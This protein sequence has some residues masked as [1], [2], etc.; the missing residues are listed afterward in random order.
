MGKK[1]KKQAL[2]D[3]AIIEYIFGIEDFGKKDKVKARFVKKVN[4]KYMKTPENKF[5]LTYSILHKLKILR[6]NQLNPK[7][8][9]VY[10]IKDIGIIID[11]LVFKIQEYRNDI[12]IMSTDMKKTLTSEDSREDIIYMKNKH[13]DGNHIDLT[14]SSIKEWLNRLIVDEKIEV[15]KRVEE[16]NVRKKHFTKKNFT[17]K[18]KAKSIPQD[19][20]NYI[21]NIEREKITL[22]VLKGVLKYLLNTSG[23]KLLNK[24]TIKDEVLRYYPDSEIIKDNT[25]TIG[26]IVRNIIIILKAVDLINKDDEEFPYSVKNVDDEIYRI[27]LAT[28]VEMIS[29]LIPSLQNVKDM[30]DED[31]ANIFKIFNYSHTKPQTT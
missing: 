11:G 28:K 17:E 18:N 25:N 12:D 4:N 31:I 29:S 23:K 27:S 14:E 24:K 16:M 8:N 6:N 9:K 7:Y 1:L 22:L 5:N 15:E 19:D 3:K 26:G 21:D 2:F 20:R 10:E 13:Y 30:S